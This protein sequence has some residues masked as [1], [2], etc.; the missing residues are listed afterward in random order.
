MA[1]DKDDGDP[2][3]GVSQLALKIQTVDSRKSHVQDKETG[4]VGPFA[5]Q[6]LLRRAES[7]G[8]QANR[9]QQALDGGTYQVI[10]IDDKN[11][12]GGC[13]RHLVASILVSN[14]RAIA[15]AKK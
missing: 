8:P 15:S 2:D 10:V 12:C 14:A 7:L 4:P 5:A 9:P 1:G 11:R 3:S 6:K 13:R